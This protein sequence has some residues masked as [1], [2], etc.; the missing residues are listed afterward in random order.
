MALFKKAT[1]PTKEAKTKA[2]KVEKA[3]AVASPTL[4]ASYSALLRA[5][6]ITE[7]ASM[8]GM[9]NVYTFNV[10][11]S[12]TKAEIAKAVFSLYKVKP[13]AVNVI[14][15]R[16]KV[17]RNARTGKSGMSAAGKKAYVFLKKGDSINLV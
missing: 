15:I 12:A 6:R 5:P 8:Q 13:V 10:A 1:K 9:N 2:P 17:R 4:N 7:K 16:A 14:H 3:V 11:V